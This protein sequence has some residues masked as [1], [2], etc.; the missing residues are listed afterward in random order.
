DLVFWTD[1]SEYD[2]DKFPNNGFLTFEGVTRLDKLGFL[3]ISKP[4][5]DF[6]DTIDVIQEETTSSETIT[7]AATTSE[8]ID[9]TSTAV[10]EPISIEETEDEE[11]NTRVENFEIFSNPTEITTEAVLTNLAPLS[12]TFIW[13]MLLLSITVTIRRRYAS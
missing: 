13:S 2:P 4:Q 6:T 1:S 7:T 5:P 12:S 11:L 3:Y 9:S 8:N 10:D